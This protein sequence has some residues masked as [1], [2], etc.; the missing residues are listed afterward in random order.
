MSRTV[1]GLF[2]GLLLALIVAIG[3][4]GGF[5]AALFFG[6]VGVVAGRVLDGQ[7]DLSSVMKGREG[8][9]Q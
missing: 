7:L 9:R 4:F 1:I 8:G 2:A 5:M 6:A 3:G